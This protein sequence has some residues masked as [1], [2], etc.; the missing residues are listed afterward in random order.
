MRNENNHILVHRHDDHI[1]IEFVKFSKENKRES[2]FKAYVGASNNVIKTGSSKYTTHKLAVLQTDKHDDWSNYLRPDQFYAYDSCYYILQKMK[3]LYG[4][5][6]LEV[7]QFVARCDLVKSDFKIARSIALNNLS[8]FKKNTQLIY[9]LIEMMDSILDILKRS[10]E[11]AKA[12]LSSL[13]TINITERQ[14]EFNGSYFNVKEIPLMN[15]IF[16]KIFSYFDMLKNKGVTS[17]DEG[18]L[19]KLPKET[20]RVDT[21][22]LGLDS[23]FFVGLSNIQFEQMFSQITISSDDEKPYHKVFSRYHNCV[24][25]VRKIIEEM[26]AKAYYSNTDNI[27][28]YKDFIPTGYSQAIPL[29]G[30]LRKLNAKIKILNDRIKSMVEYTDTELGMLN[31]FI[32]DHSYVTASYIHDYC[33]LKSSALNKKLRNQIFK[34]SN[35]VDSST[36]LNN[37]DSLILIICDYETFI[38]SLSKKEA[39]KQSCFLY[40]LLAEVNRILS[41][42]ASSI[43]DMERDKSKLKKIKNDVIN[44]LETQYINKDFGFFSNKGS[45]KLAKYLCTRLRE[46]EI[47]MI[48]FVLGLLYFTLHSRKQKFSNI[49]GNQERYVSVYSLFNELNPNSYISA[50]I[51]V[52]DV[53]TISRLKSDNSTRFDHILQSIISNNSSVF[54]YQNY[55]IE[56]RRE[57]IAQD[58]K[59]HRCGHYQFLNDLLELP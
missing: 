35:S 1:S 52:K 49:Q 56:K 59:N 46:S 26:G 16:S 14:C 10:I 9:L 53:N 21:A 41:F 4:I 39:C 29:M 27:T 15:N 37:L 11:Y 44:S 36:D 19:F 58:I 7:N 42:N 45:L 24:G 13:A 32:E 30:Y 34:Y 43:T 3:N 12:K 33:A 5:R 6:K 40:Y 28:R 47:N 8:E 55:I 31:D 50:Y 54:K 23:K 22:S 38:F 51:Y 20:V 48:D 18:L 17:N 57:N 2:C 25:Y